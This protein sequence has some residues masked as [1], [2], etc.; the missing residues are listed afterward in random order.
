MFSSATE[1]KANES[2]HKHSLLNS[3]ACASCCTIKV[4][5]SLLC[6]ASPI[7]Y[8]PNIKENL[9][10]ILNVITLTLFQDFLGSSWLYQTWKKY[11]D[12]AFQASSKLDFLMFIIIIMNKEKNEE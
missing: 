10:I 11:D 3:G 4:S 1:S 6:S 9:S 5:N 8:P 2:D 12:F 7:S